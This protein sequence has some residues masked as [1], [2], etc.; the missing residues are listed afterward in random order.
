MAELWPFVIVEIY[1]KI[2][3]TFKKIRPMLANVA[4]LLDIDTI[5]IK[6]KA[7]ESQSANIGAL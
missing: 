3:D 4:G 6:I 1:H 2:L 5:A 7:I